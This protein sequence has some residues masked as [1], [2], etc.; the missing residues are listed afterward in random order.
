MSKI[1]AFMLQDIEKD[2][3]DWADNFDGSLKEPL[4]LPAVLPNLLINGASGIAVG[5]AT[6]MAPHNI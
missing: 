5:M 2:T 6:N 3:V 4:M 1:A